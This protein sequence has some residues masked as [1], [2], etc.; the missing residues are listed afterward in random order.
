MTTTRDP[1]MVPAASPA[2][3]LTQSMTKRPRRLRRSEG[4]RSLVR[5]T[6]VRPEDL[7]Y[8]LFVVPQSRQT[9][10]IGSMRGVL[11]MRVRDAVE[12]AARVIAI[13][14]IG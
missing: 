10:P 14:E 12:A 7:I 6:V 9:A 3:S 2:A 1:M 13:K 11:Q 5:E 4:I 8:P